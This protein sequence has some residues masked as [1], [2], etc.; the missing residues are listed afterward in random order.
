MGQ[1]HQFAEENHENLHKEKSQ[2]CCTSNGIIVLLQ[3]TLSLLAVMRYHLVTVSL[4]AWSEVH[5]L[6]T[7]VLCAV[8]SQ[9][10]TVSPTDV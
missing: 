6:I 10:N 5:C 4:M 1:L 3:L 7:V 2:L 9:S 8:V